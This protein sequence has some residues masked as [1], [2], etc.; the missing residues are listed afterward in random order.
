MPLS[1]GCRKSNTSSHTDSL[2]VPSTSI[3]LEPNPVAENQSP[4]TPN[5]LAQLLRADPQRE[6]VDAQRG[7]D[8]QKWLVASYWLDLT[9]E[10]RLFVEFAED[11]TV[12]TVDVTVTVQA[13]D[14]GEAVSLGR[15]PVRDLISKAFERD[16]GT[17]TILYTRGQV[18]KEQGLPL[19][20]PGIELWR[21]VVA[22]AADATRLKDYLLGDGV[23]SAAANRLLA[24][25]NGAELTALLTKVEWVTNASD[26]EGLREQVAV[27]VEQRMTQLG[28]PNAGVMRQDF[29]GAVFERIAS[30]G[31]KST[32]EQRVL[33]RTDLD[34]LLVGQ[35]LRAVGANLPGI[36]SSIQISSPT[37][38]AAEIVNA[39]RDAGTT[40]VAPPAQLGDTALHG[41][42]TMSALAMSGPFSEVRSP[43]LMAWRRVPQAW[44]RGS[45]CELRSY[46]A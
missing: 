5:Q 41:W 23:L 35:N 43:R 2:F 37:A 26:F 17:K 18:G 4:K 14:R 25:A 30:I 12:D 39:L 28:I 46:P 11:L 34:Q 27:K 22:D 36:Q 33:K 8:W 24:G 38:V 31:A 13:K 16:A 32:V 40:L 20:E 9:G 44:G 15:A 19:G 1:K 6:A 29:A 21:R 45:Q 10:D 42:N 3:V 7:Y